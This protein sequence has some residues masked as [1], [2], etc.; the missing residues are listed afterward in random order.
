MCEFFDY[1]STPPEPFCANF[2]TFLQK[3]TKMHT[4]LMPEVI[5]EILPP[6]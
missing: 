1:I 3:I 6:N 5:I 2:K 4:V